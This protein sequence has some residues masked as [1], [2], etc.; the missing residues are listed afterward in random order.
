[1]GKSSLFRHLLRWLC[2]CRL[3][4]RPL[5]SGFKPMGQYPA[6]LASGLLLLQEIHGMF[7]LSLTKTG[8]VGFFAQPTRVL[9][10]R[11]ALLTKL[12]FSLMV[13]L[14]W[15]E[16][17]TKKMGAV[18]ALSRSTDFGA[19]WLPDSTF[20]GTASNICRMPGGPSGTYHFA[21]AQGGLYRSSDNGSSWTLVLG[22]SAVAG[23]AISGSTVV[24]GV[25]FQGIYRSTDQ[26]ASWTNV[27]PRG[28]GYADWT[29]AVNSNAIFVTFWDGWAEHYWVYRSKDGG[30]TF[31]NVELSNTST[32]FPMDRG[33]VASGGTVFVTAQ[34]GVLRSTDN[35][36]SWESSNVGLSCPSGRLV[37]SGSDLFVCSDEG[38]F[39]STDVGERWHLVNVPFG[40]ARVACIAKQGT[41]LFAT[42]ALGEFFRSADNGLNWSVVNADLPIHLP[43]WRDPMPYPVNR[44]S[45]TFA[46]SRIFYS[47]FGP[48]WETP[49]DGSILC[50]TDGGVSWSEGETGL[51]DRGITAVVAR[52]T[53]LFASSLQGGVFR[54][55]DY[56]PHWSAVN[57]GLTDTAIT[58]LAVNAERGL[59]FA[60]TSTQGVFVSQ[61]NGNS[62]TPC[63]EGISSSYIKD[64][65]VRGTT[66]LAGTWGL[67]RS[68]NDGTSW[69][70][71]PAFS[72]SAWF[73]AIA[74]DPVTGTALVSPS[75][76]NIYVSSDD[77]VNWWDANS[78]LNN[79]TR[80]ANCIAFGDGCALIGNWGIWRRSLSE[81]WTSVEKSDKGL[82][83][84]FAL[85]Q[86][87][88]NPF[89]PVTSIKYT[90]GRTRGSDF[91]TRVK[92][93]V[94]GLLGRELVVL[95]D[96][97]KAGGSY[98]VSF[99]G[100]GLASGVYFY[101]MQAGISCRPANCY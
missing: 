53:I 59:I 49:R 31:S 15:L 12:L 97:K 5:R 76:S 62:W 18:V 91:G 81:A 6:D 68:G 4:S 51:S 30:N 89:N 46:G 41:T 50:S 48:R 78:G 38:F 83:A 88:P 23:V 82:P 58:A 13:R 100:S 101:R 33:I 77:G 74:I 96:E 94:Y 79:I 80:K 25:D 42:G 39:R 57:S 60:S 24:V 85:E 92:L 9:A 17:A 90:I 95:V 28:S 19:T 16:T 54:S 64:L 66:V 86:N 73:D 63:H 29:F 14:L 67:F 27:L 69:T 47:C 32:I 26:G 10:G 36:A 98:E 21:S 1:M 87:Y 56:G 45:L 70:Q 75:G 93:A 3:P 20:L 43:D 71:V 72:S 61:D 44:K 40:H 7:P 22:T 2:S 11:I 84:Q 37:T 65:A 52:D 35:G 8:W 99:D 55:T 34:G